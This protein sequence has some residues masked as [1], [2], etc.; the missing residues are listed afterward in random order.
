MSR[1]CDVL[2]DLSIPSSLSSQALGKGFRP[3]AWETEAVEPSA[4]PV[5]MKQR[6]HPGV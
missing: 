4:L 3:K 5:I 6:P 2:L 1:S